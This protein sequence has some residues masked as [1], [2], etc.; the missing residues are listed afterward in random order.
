MGRIAED[1]SFVTTIAKCSAAQGLPHPTCIALRDD[2]RKLNEDG[3]HYEITAVTRRG[4]MVAANRG[5][6]GG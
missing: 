6:S 4:A 1:R 3:D 2:D 5:L